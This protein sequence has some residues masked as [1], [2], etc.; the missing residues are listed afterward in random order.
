MQ[1]VDALRME[2]EV[3]ERQVE[4]G[5]NLGPGPVVAHGAGKAVREARICGGNRRMCTVVHGTTMR[6]E[7]GKRKQLG[8]LDAADRVARVVDVN[9]LVLYQ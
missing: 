2:D 3:R 4:Q 9:R 5:L 6:A 8:Q 7:A 1:A